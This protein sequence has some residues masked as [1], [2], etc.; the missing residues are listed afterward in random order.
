VNRLRKTRDERARALQRELNKVNSGISRCLAFITDGDGDPGLV[1]DELYRLQYQKAKI[2]LEIKNGVPENTIKPHP[3]TSE[4]YRRK[5]VELQSLLAEET[6]R[7]EAMEIM[8]SL[9]D[10]IDVHAGQ[11]RGKSTVIL[12]GALAGILSF[13]WFHRQD[14]QKNN[15]APME[16]NGGRALMVAGAGF[17]QAPTLAMQV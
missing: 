11:A 2:E 14:A 6:A 17:G 7:P 10:H 9:V 12:V 4:L 15:T 5:V 8:R 13:T 1:R 16:K 3:N